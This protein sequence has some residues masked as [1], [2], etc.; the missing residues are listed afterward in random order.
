MKITMKDLNE[1]GKKNLSILL[2]CALALGVCVY[3]LN[4]V[5]G[6]EKKYMLECQDKIDEYQKTLGINED[7]KFN[8]S[9]FPEQNSFPNLK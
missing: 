3:T 6:Y 4:N 8:V 7:F 5:Q 2:V 1:Y 9:Q